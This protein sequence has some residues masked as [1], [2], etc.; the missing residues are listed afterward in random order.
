MSTGRAQNAVTITLEEHQNLLKLAADHANLKAQLDELRRMIFGVKSERFISSLSTEQM[1]LF[2]ENQEAVTPKDTTE[3]VSYTRQKP[4]KKQKPIRAALPSHLPRV[5]EVLEPENLSLEA[6]KIGEEITEVLEYTPG[7]MFV[8]KIIRPKYAVPT[9]AID[10]E[11]TE[12]TIIIADLPSLPIPRGNAAASLL[13]HIQ[14]SKWIDHLPYYRQTQIYKRGGVEISSSTINDWFNA[15]CTL[16]EPLYELLK[17][18]IIAQT[19]L[20]ADES[21]LKVQDNHKPARRGG[22]GST[23]LGYHWVYHAPEIK[24]V[25]FDYQ[26]SRSKAGPQVFL[27]NF[28]GTLQSDGYKVYDVLQIKGQLRQLACMAHARRKFDQALDND[29]ARAEHALK[30]IQKLYA[31]ERKAKER[32]VSDDI[33]QRY[34]KLYAKPIL[35]TFEKW[36]NEEYLKVLPK[37]K[38]GIALAYTLKLFTRLSAYTQEGRYHIDNNAIENSIR[39]LALGRKNYLFAGSH[40]AAQ[41]AAMMYSFFGTCKLNAIEPYQWLKETLDKIPEC[42]ITKLQQLLPFAEN[43]T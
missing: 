32:E 23:H 13:A 9:T 5:E 4:A 40:P 18:K 24:A 10:V 20:Q 28:T 2:G 26:P 34:R 15:T 35:D 31:I 41:K 6:K 33:R 3:Q 22:K 37:S 27:E 39:P 16:L 7:N 12:N 38:I 30:L 21:P 42:N 25:C 11:S 1:S 29:R 36:L 43:R 17:Q 8:R 19:Y 14:V